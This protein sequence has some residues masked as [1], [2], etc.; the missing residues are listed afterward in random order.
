MNTLTI[1]T[2]NSLDD[3]TGDMPVAAWDERKSVLE[4]T[5]DIVRVTSEQELAECVAAAGL[6]ALLVKGVKKAYDEAKA[7]IL[8]ATR[9]LDAINHGF[10]DAVA[11]EKKR[12]D[13]LA[14]AYVTARDAAARRAADAAARELEQRTEDAVNAGADSDELRALALERNTLSV[15][16]VV[17][18]AL[19][20]QTYDYELLDIAALWQAR[21]DLVDITPRRADILRAIADGTNIAGLRV[22]A[23]TKVRARA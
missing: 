9:R 22:Y 2:N 18:G 11:L 6:A 5:G 7:P 15:K 12:L 14:T 20:R 16:P 4:M 23:E 19:A 10:A 13:T 17:T 1:I 8:T 21:P 3:F